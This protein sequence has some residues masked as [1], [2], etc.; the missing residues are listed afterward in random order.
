MVNATQ[1]PEAYVAV[2]WRDL[3]LFACEGETEAQ[4]KQRTEADAAWK[5]QGRQMLSAFHI[6]KTVFATRDPRP[7]IWD[8]PDK[9]RWA[10][11]WPETGPVAYAGNPGAAVGVLIGQMW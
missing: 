11:G 6:I 5:E 3:T 10:A 9:R 8:E 1:Y 7:T 2:D 4:A